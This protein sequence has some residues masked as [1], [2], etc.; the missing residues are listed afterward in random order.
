[1]AAQ[2]DK[3]GGLC[4]RKGCLGNEPA[5]GFCFTCEEMLCERHIQVSQWLF[6]LVRGRRGAQLK[7]RIFAF[8]S[9]CKCIHSVE[10]IGVFFMNWKAWD[11]KLETNR[12]KTFGVFTA[13]SCGAC[14]YQE[15]NTTGGFLCIAHKILQA[16]QG[17]TS[18]FFIRV[19]VLMEG[20]VF[21]RSVKALGCAFP[22][23]QATLEC[24]RTLIVSVLMWA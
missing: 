24:G 20:H 22:G 5:V 14:L 16:R 3:S 1:M 19:A 11:W 7:L 23:H 21:Y 18:A 15:Y 12:L 13:I 2:F 10:L 8:Y 6:K 4:S 9:Y 17:P